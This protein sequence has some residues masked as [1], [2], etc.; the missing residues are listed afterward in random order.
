MKLWQDLSLQTTQTLLIE[1]DQ[2]N[3]CGYKMAHESPPKK[4][5]ER[6]NEDVREENV[7]RINRRKIE[8][9]MEEDGRKIEEKMEE[10]R[11]KNSDSDKSL[12]KRAEE[13]VNI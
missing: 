9:K 7:Q 8:E 4:S 6:L 11:R 12:N 5:D 2:L 3:T 10:N 13:R 1:D